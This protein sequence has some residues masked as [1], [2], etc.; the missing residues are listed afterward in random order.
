M[1]REIGSLGIVGMLSLAACGSVD[2]ESVG[3][4]AF[5]VRVQDAAGEQVCDA[6]VVAIDGD[7][8]EELSISDSSGACVYYG[9]YERSGTYRIEAARDGA[10]GVID[11]VE[12]VRAGRC[13]VL[14]TVQVAIE[15]SA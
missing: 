8:S 9:V 15:L 10:T 13:D 4:S 2:C 5:A 14:Q 12:V 11:R 1:K 6:T 3:H 7:F